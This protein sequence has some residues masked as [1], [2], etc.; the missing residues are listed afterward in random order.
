[1][2]FLGIIPLF[3]ELSIFDFETFLTLKRTLKVIFQ[4]ANLS[5]FSSRLKG[6]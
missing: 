6:L 5:T 1:M 2:L 4:K 3:G